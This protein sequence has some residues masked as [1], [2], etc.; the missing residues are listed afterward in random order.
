MD[1]QARP[2]V[3]GVTEAVHIGS[4]S[5]LVVYWEP[6]SESD[7]AGEILRLEG[8]CRAEPLTS[9]LGSATRI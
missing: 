8:R 6:A 3:V 2:A 1:V 5:G 9:Y 7:K 4:G